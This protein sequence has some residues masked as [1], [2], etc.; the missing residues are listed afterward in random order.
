MHSPD[1]GLFVGNGQKPSETRAEFTHN[2]QKVQINKSPTTDK[3]VLTCPTTR[4]HR[5]DFLFHC[6][7]LQNLLG[8]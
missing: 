4:Y 7:L 3:K 8:L 2:V 6:Q 5:L 1:L